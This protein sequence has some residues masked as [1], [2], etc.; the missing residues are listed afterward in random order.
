MIYNNNYYNNNNKVGASN[1]CDVWGFE[2]IDRVVSCKLTVMLTLKAM[3]V[4]NECSGG[5]HCKSVGQSVSPLSH[6][7]CV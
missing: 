6:L 1:A 7:G 2:G 3:N 4:F 5:V